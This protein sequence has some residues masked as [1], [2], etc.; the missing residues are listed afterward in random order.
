MSDLDTKLDDIFRKRVDNAGNTNYIVLTDEIK[1]AFK[2]AGWRPPMFD[3]LDTTEDT[4]DLGV[5]Q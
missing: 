1:Q 5:K 3:I 2:D 4:V